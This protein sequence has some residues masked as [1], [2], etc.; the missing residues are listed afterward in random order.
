M[1]SLLALH[2]PASVLVE[3]IPTLNDVIKDVRCLTDTEAMGEA[4][5]RI[6]QSLSV[7][8]QTRS[9]MQAALS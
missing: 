8:I 4:V 2:T 7:Y 3:G 1:R 9:L 5:S 6:P